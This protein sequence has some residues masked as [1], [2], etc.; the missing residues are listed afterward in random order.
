MVSIKSIHPFPARMA[1]EIALKALS[2]L[3]AGS[4]ILDPMVGSGTV[5]RMASE[6]GYTGIGFD[7]DPLAVLLTKVWTTPIDTIKLRNSAEDLSEKLKRRS[8]QNSLP[9]WIEY[10]NETKVFVNFWFA[11]KQKR[12]LSC[13]SKEINKI[14]GSIGDALKLALSRLII[15]KNRGASLARDVSHGRPHRVRQ[16]NDFN[17]TKEFEKAVEFLITRLEEQKLQGKVKVKIGDARNL[18]KVESDSIDAI[19]TSPPY[20]NAV[21]YLR[22]HKLSLVW[23]GYK[24]SEIRAIRS[25]NIG[26]EKACEVNADLKLA[27]KMTRG[28]GKLDQLNARQKNIIQRYVLDLFQMIQEVHRTL[29]SNRQA[30]FVIGNSCLCD[31]YINNAQAIKNAAKHV[32]LR[33]VEEF[34]HELPENRRY[35]PPPTKQTDSDLEK[36]MRT[37]CVITFLK[38]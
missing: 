9:E 6:F 22:G 26:V 2:Y 29:K 31:I 28:M 25:N 3:P 18:S 16:K 14:G 7:S 11:N 37:E 21:D 20:L 19:L 33:F 1:P 32:D 23:L 8:C 30:V 38:P 27:G 34:E 13:L 24:I 17:V 5:L 15:T 36:R 12:D 35:L 10:D 4:T